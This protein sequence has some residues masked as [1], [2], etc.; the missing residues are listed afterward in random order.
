MKHCIACFDEKP[1]ADFYTHSRM[2][3]GHLNKCILCCRKQAKDRNRARTDAGLPEPRFIT[4]KRKQQTA[5]N[6]QKAKHERP[7]ARA[8][9]I[10][11]ANALRDG[12]LTKKTCHVCRAKKVHA[13]HD[14]YGKPLEVTWLCALHHS[15][16][17][18]DLSD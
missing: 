18:H 17:H 11:V 2:A 8:A 10:A 6:S 13:H 14:D 1:L 9:H 5:A 16:L 15:R 3:D 12:R 7:Q 4:D